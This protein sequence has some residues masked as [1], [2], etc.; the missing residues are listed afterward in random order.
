MFATITIGGL[1]V[2][3]VLRAASAADTEER[4]ELSADE[5]VEEQTEELRE[6]PD[7]VELQLFA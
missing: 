3:R 4:R 1:R 6:E 2:R 7:K 5:Q